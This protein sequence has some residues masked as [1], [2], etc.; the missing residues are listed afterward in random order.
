[1]SALLASA[2]LASAGAQAPPVFRAE[3]GTVRVEVSVTRNDAP[4]GGLIASDFEL[5]DNGRPQEL[6][7]VLEEK[8]PVD[9]ALVLD[10]SQSVSGPKLD[11]LK[12]AARV[13]LDGL[14]EGEQAALVA[15]REEVLLLEPFTP[16]RARVRR[17]LDRTQPRGSTAL[18]DAVYSALRLRE[19]GPRR[20]AVVVFSDGIDS[21]SWLTPSEVLEAASRSQ[22]IVYGVATRGRDEREEPFLRNLV[23]ATGGRLFEAES[24]RHLRERFVDVLADIRTRYVLSFTPGGADTAGWHA[25]AVRLR[26]V[27]GDVLARSGYSRGQ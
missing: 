9:A 20:T 17:A 8:A 5:R 27:R 2:L 3:V 12:D 23:R 11:A 25:L 6:Q 13:F 21:M 22:A 14:R 16:D 15:F 19:P 18:R 26:R 4:L 7:L 24:E 10:M 1:M